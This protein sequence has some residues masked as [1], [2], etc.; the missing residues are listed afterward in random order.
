ME[1]N[2]ERELIDALA[3]VAGGSPDEESTAVLEEW[4]AKTAADPMHRHI[5]NCNTPDRE[6]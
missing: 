5:D 4:R 6:L 3:D 2:N 1:S